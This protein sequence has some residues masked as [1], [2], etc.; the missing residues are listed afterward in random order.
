MHG[1]HFPLPVRM[2]AIFRCHSGWMSLRALC[3]AISFM[4]LHV[5]HDLLAEL[6]GE[7]VRLSKIC[8]QASTREETVACQDTNDGD[9]GATTTT[10]S[11]S[12]GQKIIAFKEHPSWIAWLSQAAFVEVGKSRPNLH[13][14]NMLSAKVGP[15]LGQPSLVGRAFCRVKVTSQDFGPYA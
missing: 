10:T 13:V 11:A 1:K 2:D 7:V 12:S 4:P 8:G 5:L 3:T 15:N 14:F 9:D 6:H